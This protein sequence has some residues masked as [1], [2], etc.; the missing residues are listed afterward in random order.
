MGKF[1]REVRKR[2]SVPGRRPSA[3]GCTSGGRG[4]PIGCRRLV[5][6]ASHPV[7]VKLVPDGPDADAKMP[8]GLGSIPITHLEGMQ[9]MGSFQIGQRL[10]G[11]R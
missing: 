1:G 3:S 2:K 6:A 9:D 5:V 4:C 10:D 8:G 7:F 11:I